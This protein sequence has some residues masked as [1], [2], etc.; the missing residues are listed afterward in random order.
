MFDWLFRKKKVGLVLGGGVARA[1]AHIGVLKVLKAYQV[2]IDLIAGTSAGSLIAAV[3]ASGMEIALLEEIAL[4]I[5]WSDFFKL[6]MFR[7]GFMSA[8]AIEEFV[9]RYIG[10]IEISDLKLPY[11]AVATDIRT[12]ARVVIDRGPVAKAVAASATFPGVFAP[13][14]M[15]GKYLIDGGIAANVPVDVARELG[16]EYVIASDVIPERT[17]NVLPGEAMQVLSRA[18]DLILKQMHREE[19]RRADALVELEMEGED[20]W[21]LDLHKAKKLITAG[22]IAAHRVINKIRKDLRLRASS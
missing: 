2:P 12:G 14:V 8:A 10:D 21:H 1:I 17:I 3:Y 5:K 16:A 6:T 15:G 19:A 11:A 18:L 13:E 4:R 9:I 20:I 22:E 7:P